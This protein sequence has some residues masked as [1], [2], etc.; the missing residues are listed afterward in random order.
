MLK[1]NSE[2]IEGNQEFDQEYIDNYIKRKIA[3]CS[4]KEVVNY[5]GYDFSEAQF[6]VLDCLGHS[7]ETIE[8]I[9]KILSTDKGSSKLKQEIFNSLAIDGYWVVK[10]RDCSSFPD[11]EEQIMHDYYLGF[12]NFHSEQEVNDFFN[13]RP[14]LKTR[15]TLKRKVIKIIIDRSRSFANEEEE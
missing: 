12:E 2:N 4:P 8:K 9:G 6:E 11:F 7:V 13:S 1:N 3:E 15:P 10:L 14:Y 5:G